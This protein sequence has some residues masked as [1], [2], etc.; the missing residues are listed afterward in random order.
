MYTVRANIYEIKVLTTLKV[1]GCVGGGGLINPLSN[2]W[3]VSGSLVN[4]LEYLDLSYFGNEILLSLLTVCGLL[5]DL[6]ISL[7]TTEDTWSSWP[8]MHEWTDKW[9]KEPLN[10][11]HCYI[12]IP[13]LVILHMILRISS[14][15]IYFPIFWVTFK[16]NERS[17]KPCVGSFGSPN[18]KGNK[19]IPSK[20]TFITLQNITMNTESKPR[21][22]HSKLHLNK[23]ENHSTAIRSLKSHK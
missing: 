3:S 5:R 7:L 19:L 2:L 1:E 13:H 17:H 10:K 18:L 4:V 11:P 14:T 6:Y 9:M 12:Q 22:Y 20:V 16:E 21:N 23:K 15:F 8:S